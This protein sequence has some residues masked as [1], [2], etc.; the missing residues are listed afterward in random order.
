MISMPFFFQSFLWWPITRPLFRIFLRLKIEGLENVNNLPKGAIFAM[1]HVNELDAIILP[2]SL[3]QFSR[4]MPMY[5]V[6]MPK[7]G[8]KHFG[9][10][11]ALYGGYLFRKCGAY[12]VVHG[13]KNYEASL[14]DHIA[15]L[16]K[17]KSVCIFPEGRRSEDGKLHSAR[18]GV[19]ALSKA[20]GRPIV[21]VAV[22]GYFG[23]TFK[24]FILRKRSVVIR[25]GR[26]IQPAELFLGYDSK[27]AD[28][29]KAIADERV[30]GRIAEMLE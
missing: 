24:E 10:K 14:A 30:M 28:M 4:H 29:F 9:F 21:P 8:Y 7:D 13:L 19:V 23:L 18:G 3:N 5:F 25:F 2:T 20:T 11:S 17:G 6:A 26:A 15:L 22:S 27:S 12:P 1:N 16:R